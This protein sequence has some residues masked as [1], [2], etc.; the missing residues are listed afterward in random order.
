MYIG[1]NYYDTFCNDRYVILSIVDDSVT[2]LLFR[3]LTDATIHDINVGL[4]CIELI[5]EYD[6]YPISNEV[7]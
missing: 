3:N 7:I 2:Y 1:C 5:I 4:F 6:D